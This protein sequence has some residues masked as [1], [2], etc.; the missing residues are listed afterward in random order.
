[1]AKIHPDQVDLGELSIRT[2]WTCPPTVNVRDAVYQ[3]GANAVDQADNGSTTTMPCVGIVQSKPSPTTC[4]VTRQGI[5]N[6]FT[7]AT[8]IPKEIYY[9]G[10]T[11]SLVNGPGVPSSPGTVVHEVGFAKNDTTLVVVID[12]DYTVL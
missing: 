3:T 2:L 7:P 8:F 4:Y 5:V 6:G 10:T 11:G 9:V 1:M 12:Q